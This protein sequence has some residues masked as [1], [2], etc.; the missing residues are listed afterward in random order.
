MNI[1]REF[2][3]SREEEIEGLIKNGTFKLV[4][5]TEIAK[6]RIFESRFTDSISAADNGSRNM[7]RLLAQYY[8]GNGTEMIVTKTPT[9]EQ[10]TQ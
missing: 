2:K 1:S 6:T 4:N 7:C 3:K 9:S 8:G 5:V 10:S